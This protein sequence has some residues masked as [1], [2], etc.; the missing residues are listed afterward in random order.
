MLRWLGMG[1]AIVVIVLVAG[2]TY[3]RMRSNFVVAQNGAILEHNSLLLIRHG[4][5]GKRLVPN[6]HVIIR[7]HYLSNKDVRVDINSAGFRDDELAEPKAA[8][9]LRIVVLGDSITFG[10]YL[11]ADEVYEERAER[12]LAAALPD[13]HVEVIN[14]GVDDIGLKDEVDILEES[15]LAVHPDL[16]VVGF[17]MNDSRPPWGFPAELEAPGP[18]RRRSLVA[19]RVYRAMRLRS[20][21]GSQ[22]EDRFA[23]IHAFRTLPWA[24]DREAFQKLTALARYDWGAAWTDEAWPVLGAE[25][26]RL[27]TLSQQHGFEVAG[28]AFPVSFQVY[29]KFLDDEPQRRMAGEAKRRGFAYLDLLPMLRAHTDQDLF[30]DQCH[31]REATN[32][33]IGKELAR[34]LLETYGWNSPRS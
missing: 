3:L 17:Y 22:G 31:P 23:W 30:F 11:Q 26:D 28:V 8:N 7:N 14:A 2:E 29:A 13:R 32:D 4:E 1:V 21:I 6:A 18:L 34:F 12:S 25:L 16:V 20:W 10:D 5:H 15:G 27:Q 9:A 19:D 24:D 33:M